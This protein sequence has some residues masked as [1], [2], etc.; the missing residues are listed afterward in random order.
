[1]RLTVPRSLGVLLVALSLVA[2][3]DGTDGGDGGNADATRFFLPTKAGDN[4]SAPALALDGSGNLHTVYPSYAGG[5]AYYT[6]CANGCQRAGDLSLVRFETD[7]TVTNAMISLDAQGR[8][9]VLLS[10]YA[11]V[12]YASCDSGCG[13]LNSWKVTAILD[14]AGKK[15][16]TGPAFALDSQGRPRFLMHTYVAYLGVGQGAPV[17]EYVTCDANCHDPAA[18]KAYR[19][20]EQ[21]WWHSELRFDAQNH[22]RVGTIARDVNASGGWVDYGAYIECL[23]DCAQEASWQGTTLLPSY[24]D[25]NEAISLQPSIALALTSSGA[26][27]ILMLARS[28]DHQK[29]L[30]YL[31]CDS[32][33]TGAGWT[34]RT[35]STNT[36]LQDGLDLALDAQNRPRLVYTLDYNISYGSCDAARCES[37]DATWDLKVVEGGEQMKKD[38]I[39]LYPNCTVGTWFLHAPSLVLTSDG[40]RVG[41][42]AR[43]V[44][45][46]WIKK[47]PNGPNCVAGTDMTW[48][49]LAVFKP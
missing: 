34:G 2:C 8:P 33:C 5:G 10:A 38:E 22:P 32:G 31:T 45:G 46:G 21:I 4:T 48:S 35:L 39:F 7:G 19:V 3:D 27:R 36:K 9:R 6:S 17:T 15:S 40:A 43:D 16:V 41:Y 26:P 30:A 13:N 47:D 49:R 29:Q 20:A 37:N 11:K 24:A 23:G 14:H 25:D 44:S 28:T 42:Q 12:Y 18:W 1:M